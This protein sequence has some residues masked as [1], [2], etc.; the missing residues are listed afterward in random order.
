MS[1][2][3]RE[4]QEFRAAAEWFLAVVGAVDAGQWDRP[5]L[6]EWTVRE[7][8]AHTA[9]SFSRVLEYLDRPAAAED[10]ADGAEYFVVGAR[11][12]NPADVAARGRADAAALGDH[13]V[14]TVTAMAAAAL[15]RLD[16]AADSDLVTTPVGGI[17]LVAYLPTRTFELTVHTLDVAAATG[18]DTAPPAGPLTASLRLAAEM[19]AYSDAAPDV[20]LAL[21]G[22]RSLPPGF[23]AV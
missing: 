17:R 4:R 10:L 18:Q 16:R 7:L 15:E 19:A 14:D 5:G 8:V 21:T 1:R 13:P 3:G 22:R 6:G 23:S 11:E 12:I 2:D 20:L 9:R